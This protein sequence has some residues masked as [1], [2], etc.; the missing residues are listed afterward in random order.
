MTQFSKGTRRGFLKQAVLFVAGGI[1]VALGLR[2]QTAIGATIEPIGPKSDGGSQFKLY[3]IHWHLNSLNRKKGEQPVKGDIINAYG[4]LMDGPD[5]TKVGEFLSSGVHVRSPLDRGPFAVANLEFHTFNL[6]DGTIV[7]L[8]AA[9]TRLGQENAFA[10]VG[11]TG[12][13]EGARGS[14][15]ARQYPQEGGGNGTAEIVF[16]VM[17]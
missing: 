3:G 9:G 10:V 4:E 8:G 16:T 7:G 15:T 14:Y 2:K 17:S 1:G 12:R 13:Y 11:G 5:G 6:K